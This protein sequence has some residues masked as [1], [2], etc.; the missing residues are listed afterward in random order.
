MD[1]KAVLFVD[2][3]QGEICKTYRLLEQGMGAYDNA[4]LPLLN[5]FQSVPSIGSTQAAGEQAHL[6]TQWR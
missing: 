6:Y 2:N 4:R 1:T 5:E 3:S